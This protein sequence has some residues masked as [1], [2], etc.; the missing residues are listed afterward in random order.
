MP[1]EISWRDFATKISEYTGFDK[2]GLHPETDVYNDL[3]LDSL[4]LFSLGMH[5]QK[6]Y[7]VTVPVSKVAEAPTLGS[8]H[9]LLNAHRKYDS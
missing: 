9:R 4:G 7:D 8:I 1:D 6:I 2:G 5:L 3:G